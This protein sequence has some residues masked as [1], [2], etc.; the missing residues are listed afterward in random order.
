VEAAFAGATIANGSRAFFE[1]RGWNQ[2]ADSS[3]T[4]VT[5]ATLSLTALVAASTGGPAE[6]S[7]GAN[8]SEPGRVVAQDIPGNQKW[9]FTD[10]AL[11]GGGAPT[12][13]TSNLAASTTAGSNL[14]STTLTSASSS[15]CWYTPTG[16]PASTAAGAWEFSLDISGVAS[17]LT[18]LP[19]AQGSNNA[20]TGSG[21]T[22]GSEYL[23]VNQDPHDGNTTY[24]NYPGSGTRK[25]TF[26]LPDWASPPSPVNITSVVVSVWCWAST[27]SGQAAR[28]QTVLLNG[29]TEFDGSLTV[30]STGPYGAVSSTYAQYPLTTPRAWTATDINNLQAGVVASSNKQIRATEIMVTVTYMPSYSVEI[31]LCTTQNCNTRTA[32]YG[33]TTQTVFGNNVTITTPSISAQTLNGNDR[34]RFALT[35]VSGTSI[36]V[37][38]NGPSPTPGTSDSR[39]TV[40]I[41]EFQEVM[42]PILGAAVLSLILPA[43][44]RRRERAPQDAERPEDVPRH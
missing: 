8:P 35:W 3:T 41:P 1:I 20:W 23:C 18:L 6:G 30:C 9:F 14:A 43:R 10:T 27:G 2:A 37:N 31:D 21:C 11:S 13:C 5:P 12:A 34:I 15:I 28:I 38:Y 44:R 33:P 17:T 24:I 7:A 26:N 4:P 36:T 22:A 16:T 25:S 32:L 39:A 42:V 29:S 40:P 19:N